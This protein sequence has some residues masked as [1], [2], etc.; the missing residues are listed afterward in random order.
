MISLDATTTI[1]R[2][3]QIALAAVPAA[4]LAWVS[5]Y[6]DNSE[7]DIDLTTQTGVTTNI[8][9]ISIMDSPDADTNQFQLKTFHIKNQNAAAAT[10]I[11][12]YNDNATVREIFRATLEQHD[13]L[14]YNQM[15]G[16]FVTNST[17][18]IKF[19]TSPA[20]PVETSVAADSN[21]SAATLTDLY[22]VVN[23][24]EGRIIVANRSATATSF[25]LSRAP[26]GEANDDSHYFAYD[27]PIA[28]NDIYL[29]GELTAD[30]TDVFRVYA[31]LATLTFT[32][33]GQ[34]RT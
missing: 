16:W 31:T 4:E 22:T 5:N 15:H 10:V 13:T 34:N 9:A 3:L 30:A 27:T 7:D 24:F 28:G 33:H 17:G 12:Q 19:V 23:N 21:P 25:R 6:G 20:L 14:Q 26:N 11:V 18:A 32:L 29:T 2:S 8:T 1:S